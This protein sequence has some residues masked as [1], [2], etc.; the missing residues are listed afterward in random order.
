MARHDSGSLSCKPSL[1][2]LPASLKPRTRVVI[3]VTKLSAFGRN[4][5]TL[6]GTGWVQT[7]VMRVISSENGDRS[8]VLGSAPILSYDFWIWYWWLRGSKA[9]PPRATGIGGSKRAE[10]CLV[11]YA[12]RSPL[13]SAV[14]SI[15]LSEQRNEKHHLEGSG[16][17][18]GRYSD[19]VN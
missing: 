11:A 1:W 17:H 14:E 18:F 9:R 2:R 6:C 19:W 16:K 4:P 7:S 15:R 3:L 10:W 8:R 5:A 12:V 13:P